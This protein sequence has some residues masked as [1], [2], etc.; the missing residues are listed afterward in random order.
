MRKGDLSNK[1]ARIAVF[2]L[3]EIA[4]S[5][6]ISKVLKKL[7]IEFKSSYIINKMNTLFMEKDIQIV[8]GA[9]L[10]KKYQKDVENVLEGCGLLFKEVILEETQGKFNETIKREKL[11]VVTNE[12]LWI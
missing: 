9:V 8:V 6:T 3:E 5:V 12:I 7:K 4:D 11:E 10:P 2:M 1:P